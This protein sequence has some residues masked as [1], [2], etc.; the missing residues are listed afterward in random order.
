MVLNEL[1]ALINEFIEALRQDEKQQ[2]VLVQADEDFRAAEERLSN[3][4]MAAN[5][6]RHNLRVFERK[7]REAVRD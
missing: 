1:H 2:R 5:T 6:T 4:N 3:A 7:L